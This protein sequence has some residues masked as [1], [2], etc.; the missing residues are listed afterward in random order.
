[1]HGQHALSE[2]HLVEHCLIGLVELRLIGWQPSAFAL[3]DLDLIDLYPIGLLHKIAAGA[4]TAGT[5]EVGRD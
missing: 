3:L 4:V 2:Q 5:N 1:M